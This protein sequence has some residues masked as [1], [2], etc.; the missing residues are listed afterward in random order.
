MSGDE[1]HKQNKKIWN[2]F[3]YKKEDLYSIG[4]FFKEHLDGN[5]P[6]GSMGYFN[7]KICNNPTAPGIINLIKDDSKIVAITSLTPKSLFL[8]GIKIKAGEIG[9]AYTASDYKGQGM[10]PKLSN[11]AMIDGENIGVNLIYATPNQYSP[12]LPVFIKKL[13][14]EVFSPIP[15]ES[16]SFQIGIK[17]YLDRRLHWILSATISLFFS[18]ISYLLYLL[19]SLFIKRNKNTVVELSDDIPADIDLFWEEVRGNYDFIFE[20]DSKMMLWRYVSNPNKYQFLTLRLDNKLTAYMV[21]RV[22]PGETESGII[23][24]DYLTLPGRSTDLKILI[25]KL[26]QF[27]FKQGISHINTWCVSGSPYFKTFKAFGFLKRATVFL[28]C[29]QNDFARKIDQIN[30]CHFTIGDTDNV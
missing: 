2:I 23:I 1:K 15:L 11:Q 20:R 29:Y 19:K 7:W 22:I 6:Y 13:N 26:L 8:K 10:F 16:I 25:D 4:Q 3:P 18:F 30:T 14:Y 28:L 5:I 24:A 9:D 21:Y 27:S 12:S 17:K